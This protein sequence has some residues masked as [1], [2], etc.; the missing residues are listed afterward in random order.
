MY[1]PEDATTYENIYDALG[2][3][4]IEKIGDPIGW[5]ESTYSYD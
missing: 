5:D 4:I 2:N 1:L 3:Y